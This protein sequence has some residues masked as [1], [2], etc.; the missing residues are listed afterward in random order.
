MAQTKIIVGLEIGT[1]KIR[2]VVGEIYPDARAT[3]IGVGETRSRGVIKGEIVDQDAVRQCVS[4]AWQ[5]AQDHADVDILNVNLAVTGDH[6]EG[7]RNS[8]TFRLPDD[9]DIIE[10]YHVEEA[11]EKAERMELPADRFE[12]NR[13]L[14]S[15]RIDG[16]EGIRHPAGLAGRTIDVDCHIIHGLKARLQNSLLCVRQVPLEVE[17]IV[18]SPLA[19]AQVVLDRQKKEAGALLIDIGAG[20]SD[21]ICYKNGD[22]VASGCIPMGGDTITKKIMQEASQQNIQ[23]SAAEFLKCTEGDAA[24]DVNDRS[25]AHY[26]SD[27][28]V[29]EVSIQR[30]KLNEIVRDRI[31]EILFRVRDR[32]PKELLTPRDRQQYSDHI[33]IYFAGGVSMTRGLA[34]IARLVFGV[35]DVFQPEQLTPGQ[36]RDYM[37][38]PRHLTAVGLI[39]YAQRADDELQRQP[40]RNIFSR[41]LR[42]FRRR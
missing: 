34:H 40:S 38:D 5:L 28:G 41:I 25:M 10:D 20:T 24:G 15:F 37:Q 16:R 31:A 23:R 7:V 26:R 29:H 22:I 42:Y 6:I 9:E 4:E 17:N 33:K 14:G 35:Q 8:G 21:F 32:I 12:I 36:A 1:S 27:N 2:M 19:A 30:G 39:R 18:F 3:I 11:R 13:E